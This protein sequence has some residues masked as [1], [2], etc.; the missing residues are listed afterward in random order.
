MT[1]LCFENVMC[2]AAH[3]STRGQSVNLRVAGSEAKDVVNVDAS[4]TLLLEFF[5]Y[6]SSE[7][8]AHKH[9]YHI[10]FALLRSLLVGL[11]FRRPFLFLIAAIL[12]L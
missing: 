11:C 1:C 9:H 2:R 12:V 7:Q 5:V 10:P 4:G 8:L 6:R 3:K